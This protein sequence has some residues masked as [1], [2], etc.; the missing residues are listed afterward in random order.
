LTAL[1]VENPPRPDAIDEWL[2]QQT[3]NKKKYS[4]GREVYRAMKDAVGDGGKPVN[5]PTVP[6]DH[7]LSAPDVPPNESA[8]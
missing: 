1:C 3:P 7:L 4:Q 5:P 2:R 8:H 6:P